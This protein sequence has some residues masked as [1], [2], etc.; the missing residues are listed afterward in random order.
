MPSLGGDAGQLDQLQGGKPV[1]SYRNH[2][3]VYANVARPSRIRRAR[4]GAWDRSSRTAVV[5]QRRSF[6]SGPIA[7]IRVLSAVMLHQGAGIRDVQ[8]QGEGAGPAKAPRDDRC[9]ERRPADR[10]V[11]RRPRAVDDASNMQRLGLGRRSPANRDRNLTVLFRQVDDPPGNDDELTGPAR[12]LKQVVDDGCDAVAV[13]V[14]AGSN[15]PD[16]PLSL[17]VV[18]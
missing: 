17:P 2:S 5:S 15:V 3:P 16:E 6:S 8:P 11:A 10:D 7:N 12:R 14:P 18:E 9:E 4:S 13:D 1:R